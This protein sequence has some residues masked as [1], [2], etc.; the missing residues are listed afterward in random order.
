MKKILALLALFSLLS[1]GAFA[2]DKKTKKTK[3]IN[4]SSD[5]TLVLNQSFSTASVGKLMEEA[6]KL[7]ANLKSGYPIYL[8]LR[9]PGGSVQAG[10]ELFEFL[11]GLNRPVHTIT[12]FAASMGFQTVQHLG[13]RYILKYGVLMSHKA[14]GGFRGEFG[15]GFSQIDSR[16]GMWLRRIDQMDKVTVER[17]K[18]KQTLESYRAS[19]DNEMWLNG[20][21][22]VDKGYAD[23]VVVAKCGESLKGEVEETINL[24][25]FR[26]DIVRSKCPLN[27]SAKRKKTNVFTNKGLMNLEDFLAQNGSFGK[28]C[29]LDEHGFIQK[30]ALCA[31]DKTLTLEKINKEIDK[32][33]MSFGKNLETSVLYSY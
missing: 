9:T 23:E 14:R 11:K 3:I 24:G 17:T 19:Y 22:A 4:L 29:G 21:E 6:T 2:S 31:S 18:G 33:I 32:H 15:G 13:T 7:D 25:W 16:Y 30:D 12:L 26:A 8:F 5:N 28:K 1:L 27:T 10:M 20:Q